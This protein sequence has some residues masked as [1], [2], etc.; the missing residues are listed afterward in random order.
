MHIITYLYLLIGYYLIVKNY[1]LPK[2]YITLLIFFTLKIIFNYR[3]CT[4]SY[5]ECKIRGVKKE[6]GYL[7]QFLENIINIRNTNHYYILLLGVIYIYYYHFIIKNK[8]IRF[9]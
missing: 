3:K 8:N 4:I 7:Y 9:I 2:K 6:E 1:N 5:L